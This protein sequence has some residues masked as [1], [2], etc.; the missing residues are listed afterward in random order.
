MLK[1][2]LFG[3]FLFGATSC[4]FGPKYSPPIV[5]PS[6]AW[7]APTAPISGPFSSVSLDNWWEVFQDDALNELQQQA[8]G[9][10]PDLGLAFAKILEARALV[11]SNR[12]ALFPQL[13][14]S[15]SFSDTGQ[16][17]KLYVP[18]GIFPLQNPNLSVFRIHQFQYNLPFTLNYELDLWGKLQGQYEAAIFSAQSEEE[19]YLNILLTMTA[20]VA[21]NYYQLRNLDAQLEI[22]QRILEERKADAAL[23][24]S[25]QEKGVGNALEFSAASFEAYSV[26][27]SL[28][29][30]LRQ[31]NIIENILAA[32]I[33]VSASEF[34][35]PRNPLRDE[36]PQIPA[37]LP[38]HLLLR[39]PDIL[40][41]ERACASQNASIGVAYASLFPSLTLTGTLG[42][43]SPDIKQF[44]QWISRL[45]SIGA[46]ANQT[47]FDGGLIDSNINGAIARFLQASYTYQKQVLTAF[48]EVENALTDLEY[49]SAQE[50]SL[51]HSSRA[52][53]A[54][55]SL[56]NQRY[57][58]GLISYLDVTTTQENYLSSQMAWVNSRGERFLATVALIKALGGSWE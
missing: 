14:L 15:P 38:S 52:S 11:E 30:T 39:R 55:Y 10:S 19:K 41:A 20:E 27:A 7:K 4:H 31:R 33:G 36:P 44:L 56:T 21:S 57:K 46:N 6:E 34:H 47:L 42:Y 29:D 25:R 50:L 22:L 40:A 1:K 26:E 54:T 23:K 9:S 37:G 58:S 24:K 32:L 3:I 48:Q 17:F 2:I 13:N 16:L 8:I 5:N 18:P 43:S 35:L 45:W 28:T 53:E 51:L 12:S 49:R